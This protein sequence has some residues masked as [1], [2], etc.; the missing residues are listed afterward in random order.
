MDI[1]TAFLQGVSFEELSEITGE[2]L[3]EVCFTPPP[4]SEKYFEAICPEYTPSLHVL[5]MLKAVYGL[6]DAPR[7][8]RIRLHRA[9]VALGGRQ[10]VSDP[11]IYVWLYQK[12]KNSN[13]CELLAALST[14]VDDLKGGGQRKQLEAIIKGL[15]QQFGQMK[16]KVRVFEHCGILHEQDETM[17]IK[18]HQSHY[19]KQLHPMD[20]STMDQTNL[21]QPLTSKQLSEFLSLLGALAWLVQTRLDIAIYICALQRRAKSPCVEH[22]LRLNR[23]LKWCRRK[24]YSLIYQCLQGPLC[25]ATISDSAFRK[26]DTTGLAM[27]GAIIGIKEQS[28][29]TAGGRINLIDF[30]SRKQKRITRSTFAA[31]AH[32]LVD[33]YE[34]S[35]LI[36]FAATE[37]TV[38]INRIGELLQRE[39][40]G[41]LSLPIECTIDAKS[42]F[43]ALKASEIKPPTESSLILIL[44]VLKEGLLTWT[45]KRLW[46]CDTRDMCADGLNKGIISRQ[47]LHDLCSGEWKLA[48]KCI[49]FSESKQQKLDLTPEIMFRFLSL[50]GTVHHRYSRSSS[51]AL[52]VG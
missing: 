6:K 25:V 15:E 13:E 19:V 3:R 26:E 12:D 32:A 46:W 2:P 52:G 20:T 47:G 17:A 5:R 22:A 38:K 36:A 10:L 44:L 9:L 23:V 30:Y 42:V 33:S 39:A 40:V 34:I 29:E 49:G 16:L 28:L 41:E 43:D 18:L 50:L 7:A 45:L 24:P 48:H 35:K 27:R 31:E 51:R 11:A 1:S 8:W 21:Q 4:G 14:H 37:C